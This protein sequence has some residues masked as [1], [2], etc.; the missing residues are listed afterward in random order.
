LK[1]HK[2]DIENWCK[3]I[4]WDLKD[5]NTQEYFVV[6]KNDGACLYKKTPFTM[7]LIVNIKKPDT[8]LLLATPDGCAPGWC[9]DFETINW[10][11]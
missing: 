1:T 9:S 2:A 8:Y 4:G 7:K 11:R 5:N 6:D 3:V 10:I